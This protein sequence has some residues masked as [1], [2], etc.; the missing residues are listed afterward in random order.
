MKGK[1]FDLAT[2]KGWVYEQSL[3]KLFAFV[4]T[5]SSGDRLRFLRSEG[6][7]DVYLDRESGEEVRQSR[8]TGMD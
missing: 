1:S 5:E 3:S 2:P 7:I 6:G 4:P 8:S